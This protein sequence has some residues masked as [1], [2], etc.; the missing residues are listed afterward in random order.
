MARPLA[1]LVLS[2][3]LTTALAAGCGT[4]DREAKPPPPTSTA[5]PPTSGTVPARPPVEPESPP[6]EAAPQARTPPSRP[7]SWQSAGA[8]VWHE[9][10]I[11]PG[12]LA[13][14]LRGNGFG[15]AAVFL[16]EG[17]SEDPVEA[18]WVTRFR[19]A[20]GLP[21]GG[22]GVLRSN[23]GAEAEL[24][25]KLVRRYGLDFYIA[26][27]EADY[28]YSGPGGPDE[29]RYGRSREFVAAFRARQPTLP[30]G[31]SSYCRADMH[32]LAWPA[33]RD[34]GFVFLPQAYV[35]DF[36]A[37]V[38]PAVCARG[39]V[40]FFPREAVHP[41]IGMH[42]GQLSSLTAAAYVPLL[43]QAGTTGFSV[44]L[45]ETRMTAD[46]WRVLGAAI[47]TLEIAR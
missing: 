16:H 28:E 5:P 31:L 7:M 9:N 47:A 3:A 8:L 26:N 35:N 21:V 46:E 17:T 38:T 37:E 6:A 42:A 13:A 29:A 32:D 27:A 36:G 40:E 43:Q 41:T 33:W 4:G 12:I 23:P 18:D 14:E 1:Y 20:S 22:W 24:V 15:W 44:Y 11:D 45:A 19:L 25:D 30:A 2:A 10:D 39:A 34:A